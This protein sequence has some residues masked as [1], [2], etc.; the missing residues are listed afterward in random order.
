MMPPERP[1]LAGR[2]LGAASYLGFAPLTRLWHPK[3]HE[4]FFA[5]HFKQGM[6]VW[7]CLIS[8]FFGFFLFDTATALFFLLFPQVAQNLIETWAPYLRFI[9][10]AL[11]LP[12]I[13]LA[14][15][16]ITPVVFALCGSTRPLPL[17]KQLAR[18]LWI[19]RFSLVSNLLALASVPIVAAFG[20]H[21]AARAQASR[22]GA[23]VYFL[24]DEGVGVPRWAFALGMYRITLQA[25]RNWGKASTVVDHLNQDTL[26]AALASGRV[27]ILATHGEKGYAVTYF[28]PKC[29]CVAAP[30]TGAANEIGSRHFLRMKLLQPEDKGGG[31]ENVTANPNLKLAYLFACHGG[32]RAA[33]W[34]EHLSPA[35][36]VTY[37]RIS[38]IYDHAWWFAITGPKLLEQM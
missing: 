35:K 4:A 16:W 22:D 10:Y 24:Y 9:D 27:V 33:Q 2:L 13:A 6:A 7:F 17:Q 3:R 26:R 32:A 1:G 8:T 28:A 23:A 12:V 30:D 20:I 34:E 25:D 37:N 38:T 19:I 5:H 18:R 21:A 31:W 36:V 11:L 15:F 29:L 14:V